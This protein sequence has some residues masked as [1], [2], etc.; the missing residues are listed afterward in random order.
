MG[1]DKLKR[2]EEN[3]TFKNLFQPPPGEMRNNDFELKGK[4]NEK[5]FKNN[6]PITLE[7]GCGK[8]EYTTALAKVFPDR[9]FIG[10]D[11]KGA[12][13]WKGCKTAIENKLDNVAFIRNKIEFIN[14]FFD[15]N[16]VSEIWITFPD[17]QPKKL[18]KRL[19]SARFLNIY[20]N[21]MNKNGTINLKTDS[22]LMY[23]FTL[24]IIKHN[25]LKLIYENN[26]I[27]SSSNTDKLLDIKTH[28][29]KLFLN[30][31]KKITFTKFTLSE[32]EIINNNDFE[33][34]EADK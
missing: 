11:F 6:N 24:D 14:S 3:K 18:K 32:N 5:Y 33:F 29:E 17:P 15:T 12:R 21:I 30:E 16:E 26:D 23:K 31:N 19:T 27:Y 10:I 20:S 4:W 1:K 28:Y 2:F 9:N 8:G 25:N 34:E 22:V 7:V 13:L